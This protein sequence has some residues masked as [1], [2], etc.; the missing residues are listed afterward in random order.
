MWLHPWNVKW[1]GTGIDCIPNRT[2]IS[3]NRARLFAELPARQLLSHSI[4]TGFIIILRVDVQGLKGGRGEGG[5]P[6]LCHCHS[7]YI[8]EPTEFFQICPIPLPPISRYSPDY[9][10]MQGQA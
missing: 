4:S 6:P 8:P 9:V 3:S 10:I 5:I 2:H 1:A 7:P